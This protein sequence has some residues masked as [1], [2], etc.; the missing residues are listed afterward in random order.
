MKTIYRKHLTHY[1]QIS[2]EFDK[3]KLMLV[4]YG[5]S[6]YPTAK[7]ML[8]TVKSLTCSGQEV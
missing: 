6:E 5:S 1:T 4:Y 2:N 3:Y 7:Q 8:V